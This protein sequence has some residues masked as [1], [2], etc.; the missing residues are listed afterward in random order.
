MMTME[1]NKKK[2]KRITTII[3]P[4]N[5][6]PTAHSAFTTNSKT[7]PNRETQT[8]WAH[9]PNARGALSLSLARQRR[10]PTMSTLPL[11][12]TK[13][14]LMQERGS[15]CFSRWPKCRKRILGEAKDDWTRYQLFA[16]GVRASHRTTAG[17]EWIAWVSHSPRARCRVAD[18]KHT[19]SEH[20]S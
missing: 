10:W 12:P 7:S 2:K 9:I 3:S 13:I 11:M 19:E 6:A 16:C 5:I 20:K 14:A 4:T 17:E 18:C 15:K 1:E 8:E